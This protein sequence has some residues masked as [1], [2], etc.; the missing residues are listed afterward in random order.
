MILTKAQV[1]SFQKALAISNDVL[2]QVEWLETVAQAYP[3]IRE[4]VEQVRLQREM[5][6]ALAAAALEADRIL[7]V[8]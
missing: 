1:S 4:R 6:H 7:S 2:P 3:P 5:L 8:E